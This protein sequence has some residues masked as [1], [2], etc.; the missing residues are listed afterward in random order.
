MKNI[1]VVILFT[2][3][4]HSSNSVACSDVA[5]VIFDQQ[6]ITIDP[7]KELEQKQISSMLLVE[8]I[9]PDSDSLEGLQAAVGND[10]KGYENIA[11][12]NHEVL[13]IEKVNSVMDFAYR[14]GFVGPESSFIKNSKVYMSAKK[15]KRK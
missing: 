15:R 4:I 11:S 1:L 8:D 5:C 7:I 14:K 9:L 2:G 12:Q 13:A 6:T 10:L 3:I